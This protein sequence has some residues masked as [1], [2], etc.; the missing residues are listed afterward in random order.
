MTFL[1][2]ELIARKR[3]GESLTAGEIPAFIAGGG[4]WHARVREVR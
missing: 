4:L 1:P 2:Q 3:D